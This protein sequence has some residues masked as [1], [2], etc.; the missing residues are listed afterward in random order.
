EE[1]ENFEGILAATTN[2]ENNFDLAF[3]RRFLFKIK[4]QRP[5]LSAKAKIW[6][7][8]FPSLPMW[9]CEQLALQF[10]FSG[11]EIDNIVRKNE[12]R[13]IIHGKPT[14]FNT[15]L[16]FCQEEK[17]GKRTITEIGFNKK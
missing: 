16:L 3:E 13:E 17:L 1:L 9:K 12:I 5:K 8:K 6:K 7:L 2:L 10:D 15:L 11:G 14:D 4:F